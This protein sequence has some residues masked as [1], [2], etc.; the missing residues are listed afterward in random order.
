MKITNKKM[1]KKNPW[2]A[3]ILNIIPGLGYLYLGKRKVFS[4]LLLSFFLIGILDSFLNPGGEIPNTP[5]FWFAMIIVFLAFMYDAFNEAKKSNQIKKETHTNKKTRKK[6]PWIAAI[7]NIIPGLGYLYLGKR[8][9]F[10]YLLLSTTLIGT[11]DK[12]FNQWPDPINTP[13]FLVSTT[14]MFL[15]FICDAFIDA[16]KMNKIKRGKNEKTK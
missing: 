13:L 1:I 14:L 8:K 3:A 4:Y 10:S 2:I 12:F 15:A 16:K 7:L 9:V 6:N 11:I 5:L